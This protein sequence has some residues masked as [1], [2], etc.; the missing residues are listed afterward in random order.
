MLPLKKNK[1]STKNILKSKP[2]PYRST[3]QNVQ[4]IDEVKS[5]LD[6]LKNGNKK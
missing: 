6:I 1:Y 5:V 3:S 4:Y 2:E